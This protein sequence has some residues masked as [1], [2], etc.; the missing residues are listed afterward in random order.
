[1]EEFKRFE[2]IITADKGHALIDSLT[3]TQLTLEVL[4]DE[5]E[6]IELNAAAPEEIIS[7]F[8]VVRNLALYAWFSYSLDPVSQLKSYILIEHALNIKD[9]N[10][11]RALKTLLKRAVS[12]GWINDTGFRHVTL[13]PGDPQ[14][15]CK[16]LVEAL[17]LLRNSAA[18]GSNMLYQ[19]SVSHLKICADFVN[20]LFI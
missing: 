14:K 4:Y 17:P 6:R 18:H 16:T 1:M 8:N 12:A 20:Q 2:E 13:D 10:Q 5:V 3:G 11:D 9:E 15:Y 19:G 7:Q